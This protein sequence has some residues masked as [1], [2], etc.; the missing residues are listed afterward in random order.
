MG[1]L[2]P[3]FNGAHIQY[4][5]N[6][7]GQC[8]CLVLHLTTEHLLGKLRRHL[9]YYFFNILLFLDLFFISATLSLSGSSCR[10]I[11][12]MHSSR[13]SSATHSCQCVQYIRVSIGMAAGVFFFFFFFFFLTCA[14]MLTRAVSQWV[15]TATL[16]DDSR[17][18][19]PCRTWDSNPRQYCT[20]HFSRTLYQL[21]CSPAL[22][23]SE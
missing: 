9:F 17:R 7:L 16:K 12:E 19:I 2:D 23:S 8:L 15:C 13:K 14:H 20:W 10:L 1:K 22:F 4:L 5:L 6:E 21:S 11:W 18:K 3:I